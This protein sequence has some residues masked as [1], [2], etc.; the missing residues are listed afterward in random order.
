M[1]PF[2]RLKI[3]EDQKKSLQQNEWVFGSKPGVDQ[4]KTNKQK[5]R[6]CRKINGFSVQMKIGTKQSE[7]RNVFT[8][9]RWSYGF[10]S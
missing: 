7:K 1:A 6:L 8:T 4:N 2:L 10:T 9:N 3:G 5:K